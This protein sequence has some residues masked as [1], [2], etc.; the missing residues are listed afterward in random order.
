MIAFLFATGA[1]G[2]VPPPLCF[3]AADRFL[4][5][6]GLS[7]EILIFVGDFYYRHQLLLGGG[8]LGVISH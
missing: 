5:A 3:P 7:L 4:E 8:D 2:W 6:V 1:Q